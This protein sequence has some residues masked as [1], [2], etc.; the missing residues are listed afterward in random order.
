MILSLQ[1]RAIAQKDTAS[2]S[3]RQPR[4]ERSLKILREREIRKSMSRRTYLRR[5]VN[6]RSYLGASSAVL[7]ELR[8]DGERLRGET[9]GRDDEE[10]L[11][12]GRSPGTDGPRR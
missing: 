7:S 11:E 3:P 5:L 2:A 4:S 12:I 1:A 6:G 8:D 9:T 10:L